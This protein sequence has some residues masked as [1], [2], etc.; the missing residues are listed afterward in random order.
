MSQRSQSALV[1]EA[2]EGDRDAFGELYERFSPAVHG[3]LLARLQPPDAEDM[4]QE[5]FIEGWQKLEQLR[6]PDSF[7]AWICTLARRRA[8]DRARGIVRSEP[9]PPEIPVAPRAGADLEASLALD[10]IQSLAEAYR[11]PLVL[12]LVGGFSGEEIARLTGLTPG[13][14]RVNLHRGFRL[15]RE[16]MGV[17]D[18]T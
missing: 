11:E 12:R 6:S 1:A 5:V 7:G 8:I 2:I 17:E 18:A 14:V 3:V 13:S 16:R 15:L 4:V 9:L 10:A